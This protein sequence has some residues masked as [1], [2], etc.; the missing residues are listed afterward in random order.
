MAARMM[1]TM[2]PLAGLLRAAVARRFHRSA[3]APHSLE[4]VEL[5]PL[6]TEHVHDHVACVDKNQSQCGRPSTRGA[7]A[8]CAFSALTTRSAIAPTWTFDDPSR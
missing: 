3:A 8:P 4:I 7:A 1:R 2:A 5:P 6:R